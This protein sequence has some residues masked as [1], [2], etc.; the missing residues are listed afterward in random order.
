MKDF[1]K[2]TD[3]ILQNLNKITSLIETENFRYYNNNPNKYKTSDCVI[4]AIS[5]ALDKSWDDVLK[6]L[7]SYALKYK[8]FINCQ[9]LYEIYLQD[10]KWEKHK[11][12]QKDNGDAYLLGDWL[13][14]FNGQA[15]VTIDDDH[16]T[17]VSENIVY[18]IWDCTDNEVGVFWTQNEV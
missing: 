8:Y 1:I 2:I 11:S 10:N 15:I 3:N 12:P 5:V 9:E 16:L 6:D 4:R 7:T 18:D 14:Q 17:Y 13:K